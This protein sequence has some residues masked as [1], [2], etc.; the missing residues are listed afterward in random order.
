[1][2]TKPSLT[3]VAVSLS[4]LLALLGPLAASAAPAH[5]DGIDSTDEPVIK[6]INYWD[7]DA[8]VEL[9]SIVRQADSVKVK[10]KYGGA[11]AAAYPRPE[12]TDGARRKW[13]LNA[14][15]GEEYPGTRDVVKLTEKAFAEAGAFTVKV[16]AKNEA[17]KTRV[18][19]PFVA[20]ECDQNPPIYPYDCT[21]KP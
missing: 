2:K 3:A 14:G 1:M 10:V 6:R 4:L 20:S 11:T 15:F 18:T 12:Q 16:R 9:E 8:V 5:P 17:G 19:V 7:G 21:V 13:G